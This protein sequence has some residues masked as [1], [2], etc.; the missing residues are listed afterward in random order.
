MELLSFIWAMHLPSCGL[1]LSFLGNR[2]IATE[3][4]SASR[5]RP[6]ATVGSGLCSF[7]GPFLLKSSSRSIS[8]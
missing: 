4:Q 2:L 5:R 8:K 1:S 7:E 6:I 3:M